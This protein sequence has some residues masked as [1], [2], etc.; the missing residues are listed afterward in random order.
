MAGLL[1]GLIPNI[2]KGVGSLI[3]GIAQNK[4]A[5]DVLSGALR[6]FINPNAADMLP[7]QA[8]LSKM[9]SM[10]Q[11][12]I[13]DDVVVGT[14][15]MQRFKSVPDFRGPEAAEKV[16]IDTFEQLENK[17]DRL[18]DRIDE[19]LGAMKNQNEVDR[20]E[21]EIEKIE[22]ISEEKFDNEE[23]QMMEEIK[24]KEAFLN[25]KRRRRRRRR[26]RRN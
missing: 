19:T 6:S 15:P 13:R 23:E 4:P 24:L 18:D 1:A 11:R 5:G 2:V 10:P 9:K 17:L 21:A 20:L 26:E 12:I 3:G 16:E 8:E 25:R 7:Q 22:D 14:T